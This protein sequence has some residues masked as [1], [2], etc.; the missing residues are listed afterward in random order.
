MK[1]YYLITVNCDGSI[2]Y[3]ADGTYSQMQRLNKQSFH[4]VTSIKDYS[5]AVKKFGI[6]S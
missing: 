2:S 4:R 3:M 1:T 5:K 6:N